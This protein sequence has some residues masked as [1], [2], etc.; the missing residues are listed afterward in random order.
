M[1]LLCLVLLVA[2]VVIYPLIN[3]GYVED[4][5]VTSLRHVSATLLN[6]SFFDEVW[7][8][9]LGI[10]RGQGRFNPLMQFTMTSTFRIFPSLEMY[11]MSIIVTSIVGIITFY[12][13]LRVFGA[14]PAFA[15][16]SIL[17]TALCFQFRNYHDPF[18]AY[19]SVVQTPF[20]LVIISLT[21]LQLFLNTRKTMLIAASLFAYM[22][23]CFFYDSCLTLIGLHVIVLLFAQKSKE[24][25]SATIGYAILYGL[26]MTISIAVKLQAHLPADSPYAVAFNSEAVARTFL[27]QLFAGLP[28]S[29]WLGHMHAP[30]M[31]QLLSMSFLSQAFN[32][33][34]ITFSLLIIFVPLAFMGCIGSMKVKKQT[35]LL[36]GL[37]ALS[38]MV[39][40]SIP[41][42]LC[43][44]YQ[45]ELTLGLGN[46]QVYMQYFGF[47]LLA[48]L[49]C[50]FLL[51]QY[52][53]N[54]KARSFVF[55]LLC[56]FCVPV[57]LLTSFDNV[58]VVN[59]LQPMRDRRENLL[60]ALK[61]GILEEVPERSQISF[62]SPEPFSAGAPWEGTA[63]LFNGSKKLFSVKN[64][65]AM[66]KDQL[67][68]TDRKI[69]SRS[70]KPA[71]EKPQRYCLRNFW[72]G[73]HSGFVVLT[74]E[75][76]RA[77]FD[78]VLFIRGRMP[79]A[80]ELTHT[81]VFTSAAVDMRVL[82]EGRD[83][84]LFALQ[85]QN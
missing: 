79:A 8:A 81:G 22:T 4:D 41:L 66:Y 5:T 17:L 39:L 80:T 85:Q 32:Q 31:S 33:N 12:W 19:H 11:K 6:Q 13:F 14:A 72:S 68:D 58:L 27:Y 61:S 30:E 37:M 36:F 59:S 69:L 25:K 38:L 48:V 15:R 76:Q 62:R 9:T 75:N 18:I 10:L 60:A 71:L 28:L 47:G 26:L 70:G 55:A 20:I 2:I 46:M 53:S 67:E 57:F 35:N 83:W 21:T 73:K 77:P 44:K 63:F 40:P 3:I 78:E 23:G 64:E 43:R 1:L 16:L 52:E 51:Q 45:Q 42:A 65:N 24:K 7:N 34:A 84:K 49:A 54:R 50:Q 56:L 74:N 82:K 29:Y